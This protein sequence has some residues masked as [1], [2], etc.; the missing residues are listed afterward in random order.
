MKVKK[1]LSRRSLTKHEDEDRRRQRSLRMKSLPDED[2]GLVF[3]QDFCAHHG[4]PETPT[5]ANIRRYIEEFVNAKEKKIN[6]RRGLSKG[7]EGYLS[8]H[9]LFIKPVLRLM[10]QPLRAQ[11]QLAK[12]VV[13]AHVS[14]ASN[15]SPNGNIHT[16]DTSQISTCTINSNNMRPMPGLDTDSK[17]FTED[18]FRTSF[19]VSAPLKPLRSS[20]EKLTPPQVTMT[21]PL[22]QETTPQQPLRAHSK[23]N[24]A[25]HS[26]GA[27]LNAGE[28]GNKYPQFKAREFNI[29]L[30]QTSDDI[31]TYLICREANTVPLVLQEWR[32]GLNGNDAI[33]VLNNKFSGKWKCSKD[34]FIYETRLGVVKAYIRLVIIEGYSDTEAIEFLEQERGG[35]AIATLFNALKKTTPKIEEGK[36]PCVYGKDEP[37]YP[38]ELIHQAERVPRP[39]PIEE[40]GFPL[41]VRLISS[42]SNVWKEWEVGWKGAPSIKSQI[43][44]HSRVWNDPRFKVYD[45]HFRYKNQLVRTIHEAV[46]KNAVTSHEDAI[47]TLEDMRGTKEPSTF[48]KSKEFKSLLKDKWKISTS[49]REWWKCGKYR[50]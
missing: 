17:G 4:W 31:K 43:Y 2:A 9:D 24:S 49:V 21:S 48:C 3:W 38:K 35:R 32:Y 12:P 10:A 20:H 23:T 18:N 36:K 37:E 13:T 25:S 47:R 5:T 15:R 11:T 22:R 28:M 50:T 42:I 16:D 7:N 44:K 27:T 6:Q 46:K 39:P 19:T 29:R 34:K 45:N 26:Y 40:T 33:Q 1:L 41:P 30:S 8:G 14:P